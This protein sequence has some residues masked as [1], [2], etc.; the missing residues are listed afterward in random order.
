MK[1][2]DF[3][4]KM[5]SELRNFFRKGL[6]SIVM[7]AVTGAGKSVILAYVIS[8]LVSNRKIALVLVHRDNLIDQLSDRLDGF[9]ICYD[10]IG[11]ARRYKYLCMLGMVRTVKLRLGKFPEPDY[12]FVDEGH[13]S[14]APE[15]REIFDF[16]P[17]AKIVILTATPRRTDGQGL[18]EVA[19]DMVVGPPMKWMIDNGYTA[20]YRYFEPPSNIDY[21]KVRVD[22]DG[23]LNEKDEI[24]AIEKSMVAD[25]AVQ[26]YREYIDGKLAVAFCR[27]VKGAE[28]AAE[29]FNNA[30]IPARAVH[31]GMSKSDIKQALKDFKAEKIKILT[32]ADLIFEGIDIP[33]CVGVFWLRRTDSIIIFHQGN[34]RA[35][36]IKSDGGYAY[37]FDHVGNCRNHGFPSDHIEWSLDG[38]QKK[39][40]EVNLVTC[41]KCSRAFH[42][43]QAKD[44]ASSECFEEG[45]PVR[46]GVV[47]ER[48]PKPTVILDQDLVEA[49][50][51]WEWAGGIDPVLA[52]GAEYNALMAKADTEDKLKQ[53]Q[54]ARG[55]N[56]R[57]VTHMAVQKGLRKK[58][59]SF[60]K[61]E[62]KR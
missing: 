28:S 45:C 13:R 52:A 25:D 60:S 47:V 14:C 57:W 33:D 10:K 48:K 3:Q 19:D 61:Y 6:R 53:I 54:R 58:T 7:V 32:A 59:R 21:S 26:K 18:G 37:I 30:G 20:R 2:H 27:G 38:N 11:S 36:R 15:Y 40:G 56:A 44:T 23:T 46:D 62:G 9:G 24:E 51:P 42:A 29:K 12:I 5:I 49:V 34:G 50:N 41:K 39:T 55:Y 22:K 8:Q 43:N 35:F 4:M 1:L 16:F 31:G 17:N